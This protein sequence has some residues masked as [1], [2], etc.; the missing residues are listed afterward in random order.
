MSGLVSGWW[1]CGMGGGEGIGVVRG[2]CW[3]DLMVGWVGWLIIIS[4]IFHIRYITPP[5]HPIL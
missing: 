5:P 2:V 3:S 1:V 4:D